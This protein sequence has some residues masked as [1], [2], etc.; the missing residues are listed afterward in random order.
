[1]FEIMLSLWIF[2]DTAQ[3]PQK[4]L[5]TLTITCVYTYLKSFISQR[6]PF[7]KATSFIEKETKNFKIVKYY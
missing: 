5:S 6:I 7:Q 2:F 4:P 3:I 1:M